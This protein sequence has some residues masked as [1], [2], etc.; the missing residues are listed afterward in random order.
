MPAVTETL[1]RGRAAV[2]WLVAAVLLAFGSAGIVAATS[3]APGTPARADLTWVA[4]R[5]AR[6]ALDA[7]RA[8]LQ[9]IADDVQRLGVVARGAVA[10]LTSHDV[11]RLQSALDEGTVS[12]ATIE[13]LAATSRTML[14]GLAA[15]GPGAAT[16]LGPS[17]IVEHAA[18]LTA[19]DA[20][21]GLELTWSRLTGAALATDSLT[22]ML[23]DHDA[24]VA[25]AA[26][27]GRANRWQDALSTL[28][29][30]DDLLARATVLRDAIA[31]SADVTTLN[32]WLN[33]NLRYDVALRALY[34]ALIDSNGRVTDAVRAAFAEE[35]AARAQLPPDTRG[36]VVIVAEIGRGGLSSAVIEIEAIRGRLF[37]ALT[38]VETAEPSPR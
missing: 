29:D 34:S 2:A 1:V 7:A 38:P 9:V 10:A 22:G 14:T 8:D 37:E 36:L 3:R 17:L 13:R 25:D 35:G 20:T 28:A 11:D 33:R 23:L 12:A 19:L 5:E 18:M 30:A 32:E 24:I 6:P 27:L 26:T 31:A 16:R 4:D 15:F 21:R